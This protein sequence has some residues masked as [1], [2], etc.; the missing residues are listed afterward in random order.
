MMNASEDC[1]VPPHFEV[2]TDSPAPTRPPPPP[3]APV[4]SPP[5]PPAATPA[6][7]AGVP[8]PPASGGVPWR[9]GS[10]GA[11]AAAGSQSVL[12][13]SSA[14]L[15]SAQAA[16]QAKT[17]AMYAKA[18]EAQASAAEKGAALQQ[19][20]TA[21]AADIQQRGT[22]AAADIQQ[23]GATAAADV[24]QRGALYATEME[25]GVRRGVAGAEGAV[26]VELAELRSQLQQAQHELA[27]KDAQIQQLR[28][29]AHPPEPNFPRR[30]CCVKPQ[31]YHSIEND[32]PV[33]RQ[34]FL[35]RMYRNYFATGFLL[36]FQCLTALIALV[37]KGDEDGDWTA[38][39]GFSIVYLIGIPGAFV[40]W[41]W[42][43]Y[44]AVCRRNLMRYR[45]ALIGF[46]FGGG[47]AAYMA[48]GVPGHGGGGYVI[49]LIMFGADGMMLAAVFG[50]VCA[51]GW[52]LE[53]VFF[54]YNFYRLRRWYN[55]D[56][57]SPL[58]RA[59]QAAEKLAMQGAA[60]QVQ[61]QGAAGG[62]GR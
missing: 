46:I 41:Y 2:P 12:E 15:A 9:R 31:V 44:V 28:I 22:A 43:C 35:K 53:V 21:A 16:L 23:R 39:F 42:P 36:A 56:S 47:F 34:P 59:Q 37:T 32:A 40:V 51:V 24:H 17:Q 58:G 20:G 1:D 25:D 10:G 57:E 62:G 45:M 54:V 7:S 27:S 29:M 33:D 60:A 8:P 48:L 61:S 18:S 13:P 49:A 55:V 38:H 6:K 50:L 14:D 3:P 4:S 52:S 19:R 30:C 26:S 11:P 5:A